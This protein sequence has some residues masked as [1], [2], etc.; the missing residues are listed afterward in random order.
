MSVSLLSHR[1]MVCKTLCEV[2]NFFSRQGRLLPTTRMNEASILEVRFVLQKW[3]IGDCPTCTKN[4]EKI[5]PLDTRSLLH[6][7]SA[8]REY[9]N[10]FNGR[11]RQHR[12]RPFVDLEQ[13]ANQEQSNQPL[14]L[15]ACGDMQQTGRRALLLY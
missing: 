5:G 11:W 2:Q 4:M 15:L 1:C 8:L 6:T 9:S 3:F 7:Q 14:Y 10:L 13:W 12:R